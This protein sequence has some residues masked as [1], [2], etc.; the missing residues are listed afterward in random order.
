MHVVLDRL[1]GC[2][3]RGSKQRTDIDVEAEIRKGGGNDLLSAVMAVLS[4][5]GDENPRPPPFR[6]LELARWISVPAP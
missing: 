5:L 3:G 1:A 6:G 4:D 2:F